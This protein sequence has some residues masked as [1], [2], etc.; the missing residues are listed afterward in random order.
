MAGGGAG[1]DQGAGAPQA[2]GGTAGVAPEEWRDWA[3]LPEHLLMKVAGTLVSQDEAGW[4]AWLKEDGIGRSGTEIQEEMAMRKRWGNCLFVFALVCKR[5]RKAQLKVGGPLCSRVRSDVAMPGS[6]ALAKWALAEG[7]PREDDG[8]GF[9]M[10]AAAAAHGH[11]ELVRWLCG[12]GGFAMDQRVMRCA[13]L[14]GNLELVRW[15]RGEGCDWNVGTCEF[16]AAAGRLAVLQWLRAN[17]C[18]WDAYTCYAAARY[19]CLTTLRW[20]RENGCDWDEQV[21]SSVTSM[22]ACSSAAES[23]H[24]E[25]LQWL[26]AEGCPW[27]WLTCRHAFRQGHVEVLRWARENGCPMR[28]VDWDKAAAELGYTDNL[29]NLVD[30][31]GN[32]PL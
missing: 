30:I 22:G 18:P 12:E 15:L 20:A 1:V 2:P 31:H 16:A 29:G 5:W 8:Y 4:A 10:A 9:T 7:C 32:N 6:V 17:G 26:R 13:A 21:S 19:G 11:Q 25:V 14:S 3:G 23:G 24:L 28:A 27:N